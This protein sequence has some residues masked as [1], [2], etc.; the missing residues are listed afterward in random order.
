[1]ETIGWD[2]W[3]L[4]AGIYTTADLEYLEKSG[5]LKNP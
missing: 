2:I 3:R 4:L 5:K 1:M